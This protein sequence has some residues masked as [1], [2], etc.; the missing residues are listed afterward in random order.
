[1]NKTANQYQIHTIY[2][3]LAVVTFIAFEPIIH[4]GFISF[5]DDV[6]IYQNNHITGGL[7]LENIVWAFTNVHANNYHPLTSLSHM[8]DCELYGTAAGGHHFTNLLFHI[9]NTLLLFTVLSRMTKQLWASAFVA[10][11]FAIHP[12]HV[13]SVAWASE[14]K[15]TLSTFFWMLTMLAYIRYCACAADAAAKPRHSNGGANHYYILSII[16]FALASL[17]KPMVVTLPFV[18]LLLDYWPLSRFKKVHLSRLISEKIPFLVLSAILSIVTICVQQKT[19]MVKTFLNYPLSW[20]IENALVSYIIYIEKL[21][22][23]AKLAIFYPHP[24][25]GILLWQ[26]AGAVL[27]LVI[28]TLT[29]LR[30]LRRRP[31]IAVGWLWFLGTLVPVIGV[32]Q[33]GLQGYADRYTYVPYIGLFI[34]ITWGAWELLSKLKYRK[35]FFTLSAIVL[36][37]ALGIKTYVQTLYWNNNILLYKHTIDV[38]ENVWWAHH[39]LGNVFA[40]QGKFEEAVIQYKEALKV[41]SQNVTV[42]CALGETLLNKGDVNEAAKYFKEALRIAPNAEAARRGLE[43]IEKRAIAP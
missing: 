4:N 15:D 36:L 6:Y 12:L 28:I 35:V 40:S 13:E 25:G 26:I 5:D 41:D 34:A 42:Y 2:I 38:V 9:A 14:R 24:E 27:I 21:F 11:L 8:L 33:V 16:F 7:K 37:S 30:T 10:A 32:F 43:D 1:M 18:L 22:W 17:S 29:A 23:P 31:Y 20:R 3:L 39:F 19:G